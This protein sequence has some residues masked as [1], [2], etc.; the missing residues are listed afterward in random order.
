MFQETLQYSMMDPVS[1]HLSSSRRS[2]GRHRTPAAMLH[3]R[4][5]DHGIIQVQ[6]RSAPPSRTTSLL[7]RFF[8]QTDHITLVAVFPSGRRKQKKTRT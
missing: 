1:G 6:L 7:W 8:R 5:E 4:D 2:S 3:G